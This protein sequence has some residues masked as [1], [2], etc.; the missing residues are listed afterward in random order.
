[1]QIWCGNTDEVNIATLCG[2]RKG[3]TPRAARNVVDK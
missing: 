2:T 1:L 3:G